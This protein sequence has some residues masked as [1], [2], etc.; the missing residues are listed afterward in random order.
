VKFRDTRSI[1]VPGMCVSV[2]AMVD[3]LRR[4]A[5]DAVAAHVQ[6]RIDPVIDRIV[7][8]WPPN[9]AP[10]LGPALGMSADA[11]FEDIVRAYIA[12]DM[13]RV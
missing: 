2:A 7:E 6:W 13:P 11:N 1:N 3:A 12:D 8:T 5:G 10:R 9:F 4:V